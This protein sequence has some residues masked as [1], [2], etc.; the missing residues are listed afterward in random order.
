MQ[1]SNWSD[2]NKEGIFKL[3]DTF[4]RSDLARKE[5]QPTMWLSVVD[6]TE[7][8]ALDDL[9]DYARDMFYSNF[10]WNNLSTQNSFK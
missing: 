7:R 10:D 8:V 2:T 5:I 6:F 1:N 4:I 9:S 3:M